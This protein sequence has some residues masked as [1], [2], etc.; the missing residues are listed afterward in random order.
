MAKAP[1]CV[2]LVDGTEV[3]IHHAPFEDMIDDQQK[4]VGQKMHSPWWV[5]HETHQY[6]R[7]TPEEEATTQQQLQDCDHFELKHD[8]SCGALKWDGKKFIPHARFDIKQRT[9][10]KMIDGDPFKIKPDTKN[11]IPC[12]PQPE[13]DEGSKALKHW[14]HMRPI[15]EE[16]KMYKHYW[17]AFNSCEAELMEKVAPWMEV[18]QVITVEYMGP[19]FNK[20]SYEPI[21]APR[22]VL[23]GSL[24]MR[25]PK[26][27]R[28][29][30]GFEKIFA[31]F[32]IIEGVIG[33]PADPTKP[34]FKV[35]AG[36]MGIDP[37]KS[38]LVAVLAE[39]G[40][41]KIP[42]EFASY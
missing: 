35:K 6:E 39:H 4:F 12:E 20:P 36:Y 33:Y 16:P 34:T 25:V 19:E 18:G 5:S 2:F 9:G 37:E 11:W 23:H 24:T 26:E 42:A 21:P 15:S 17:T 13:I 8:G 10:K 41:E 32:P 22:I 3:S 31:A 1:I 7:R 28:T 29:Y 30:E 40:L 38:D 27:L 14:P